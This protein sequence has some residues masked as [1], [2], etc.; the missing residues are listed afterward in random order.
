M[1]CCPLRAF[2]MIRL[3][4][5]SSADCR[6]NCSEVSCRWLARWLKDFALAAHAN[7]YSMSSRISPT[8]RI[9]CSFWKAYCGE[10][11]WLC[12]SGSVQ[13]E[14]FIV[15]SRAVSFVVQGCAGSVRFPEARSWQCP[16]TNRIA[17]YTSATDPIYRE[18]DRGGSV[19][20]GRSSYRLRRDTSQKARR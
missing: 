11:V 4:R 2:R 20:A 13:N 18:I 17:T 10:V 15:I 7:E 3:C 8:P 9:P 12:L 16:H 19:V 1:P 5:T 14:A 6:R